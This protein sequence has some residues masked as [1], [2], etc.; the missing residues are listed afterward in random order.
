MTGWP[1]TIALLWVFAAG[2]CM[3]AAF[4]LA[5]AALGS[6]LSAT[7]VFAQAEST[8]LMYLFIHLFTLYLL[9]IF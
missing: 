2:I 6:S 9:W 8:L 5:A 1:L 4:A 7:P 3:G